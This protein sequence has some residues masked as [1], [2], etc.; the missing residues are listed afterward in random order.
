MVDPMTEDAL[1]TIEQN[2]TDAKK[3]ADLGNSVE[4][5]FSNRDFKKV[6]MDGYLEKEAIRLV[7]LKAHPAM[8]SAESQASIISQID[9]IG[10][11]TQFLGSTEQ[12]GRLALKAIADGE[13]MREELIAEG[14]E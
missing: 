4:R 10:T 1:Q 8:Q 9:A 6:V 2:I 12:Q 14:L 3:L 5:L 7:H 11:F 13:Q